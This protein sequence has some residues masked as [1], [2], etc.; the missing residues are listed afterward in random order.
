MGR[1]VGNANAD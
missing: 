1:Y